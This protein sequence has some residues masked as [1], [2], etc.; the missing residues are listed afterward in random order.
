[1]LAISIEASVKQQSVTLSVSSICNRSVTPKL[2]FSLRKHS[3]FTFWPFC[4]RADTL[5]VNCDIAD[6]V[7]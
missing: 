5:V 3:Q 1:M 2:Y 7:V 6:D 4:L